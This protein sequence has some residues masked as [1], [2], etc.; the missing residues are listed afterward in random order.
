MW[1][2][3]TAARTLTFTAYALAP[4]PQITAGT[5]DTLNIHVKNNLPTPISIVIRD[6]AQARTYP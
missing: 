6:R 2:S 3:P 1:A 4:A 5:T